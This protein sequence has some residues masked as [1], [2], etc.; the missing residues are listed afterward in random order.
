M[1]QTLASGI[2]F[3]LLLFILV[4]FYVF[5]SIVSLDS[6]LFVF[7][8]LTVLIDGLFLAIQLTRR[9][10][11]KRRE[12]CDPEKVSAVIACYNG[13]DEIGQTI[14]HL[15]RQIPAK[16]IIVVSDASTDDTAEVARAKGVRVIINKRNFNKAFSVSIGVH[17]V[18]TPYTLILDDDVLIGKAVIPTN[19]M[20]EGYSAVAFDVMPI[21]TDTFVNA[22]ETFEYRNSM[23]IGKS[24]R[25]KANA[26]GNVSGAIGLYRTDELQ[27]QAYLHSG[28][29][30]G[31]DEQRTLLT[32]I[33]G[34]G[35]GITFASQTVYTHVP[36]T[37]HVLYRQRSF[38]WSLAVPELFVLYLRV[39]FSPRYHYLLKA[40]KAYYLYIYLTD[41]LR[42]LF[43]WTLFLRPRYLLLTYAAY[44]VM[45][46]LV[47]L[48]TG[49]KDQFLV[50]LV[51]P[52][53][54]LWLGLCRFIGNFYWLKVKTTYFRKR[55]H[56]MVER[57]RIVGE[58]AVVMT[59]FVLSWV[60]SIFNFVDDM[61]LF[62]R[63][64]DSR[65]EVQATAFQYDA[66]F[67][68]Q[69]SRISDL[70]LTYGTAVPPAGSYIAV[71][72]EQGDTLRA[73]AHKAVDRYLAAH[74]EIRVPYAQ[75]AETDKRAMEAIK[76]STVYYNTPT[77][78]LLI[79]N[80]VMEGVFPR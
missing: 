36:N 26:I 33:Y 74:P 70:D 39:L 79:E 18:R 7:L 43:L 5:S 57:R 66:D 13:S 44:L 40:E 55:F 51:Y 68:Q 63:I 45:N 48:R 64:R 31:E 6:F 58:F 42:L 25:A 16:N 49:R 21:R 22:L 34:Q 10:A 50:V 15:L 17:A 56:R 1:V 52:F 47:W 14:D 60:V 27:E 54:T 67:T 9:P 19:L 35:K 29:F 37:F 23:Q 73:V 8:I 77:S 4:S 65:L 75:R 12:V 71:D 28:Q 24:L 69:Q 3:A 61:R 11:P 30:A 62:S 76:A 38:S 20:D 2:I 53:Y 46:T 32:H 78:A 72:A 59:V 41:P 80:R